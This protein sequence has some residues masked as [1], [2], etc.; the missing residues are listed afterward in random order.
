MTI[1]EVL[2]NGEGLNWSC[3]YTEIPEVA[4]IPDG[5]ANQKNSN[6]KSSTKGFLENILTVNQKP[7]A[8]II[9]EL[10]MYPGQNY[11][12]LKTGLIGVIITH[13]YDVLSVPV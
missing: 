13:L 12:M 4:P 11:L 1:D 9:N 5:S 2:S 6:G 8:T 10:V 7:Y 3:T